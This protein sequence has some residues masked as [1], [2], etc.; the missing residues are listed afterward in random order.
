[1]IVHESM[2]DYAKRLARYRRLIEK[3]RNGELALRFLD[4]LSVVGLSTAR[5][6]RFV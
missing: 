5:V 2:H 6:A 3:L 1:V 4:P